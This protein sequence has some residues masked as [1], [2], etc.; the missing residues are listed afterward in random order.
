ML[1]IVSYDLIRPGQSYGPLIAEIKRIGGFQI[2]FSAY[3]LNHPWTAIQLRDYFRQF[4]DAN[5][6]LLVAEVSTSNWAGFGLVEKL[7]P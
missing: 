2:M 3:A 1:Y 5:D 4:M 7:T 6:R